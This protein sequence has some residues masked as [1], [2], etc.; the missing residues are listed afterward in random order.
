MGIRAAFQFF[1]LGES[2]ITDLVAR[3]I[4]FGTYSGASTGLLSLTANVANTETV[5]VGDNT[6]TFEDTLTNVANN[7][8]VGDTRADSISNLIA[9]INA[10]T[11]SGTVYAAS[12]VKH[13]SAWARTDLAGTITVTERHRSKK[14][15]TT[16]ETLSNGSWGSATTAAFPYIV[17]SEISN[18]AGIHS[19][20]GDGLSDMRFQL[21]CVAETATSADAVGDAVFTFTHGRLQTDIG[22]PSIDTSSMRV[23][24]NITEPLRKNDGSESGMYRRLMEVAVT[25]AVAVPA[26]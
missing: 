17:L 23:G 2:T 1:L 16:T 11:G 25:H 5:V 15:L 22:S 26:F 13:P 10:G 18:L 14:G 21:D 20:A 4:A 12:T 24:T 8:K 6:Y 19:T 3:R 9:A 7:V